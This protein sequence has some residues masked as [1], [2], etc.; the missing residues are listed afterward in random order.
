MYKKSDIKKDIN[1]SRDEFWS[2]EEVVIVFFV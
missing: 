1:E 2:K